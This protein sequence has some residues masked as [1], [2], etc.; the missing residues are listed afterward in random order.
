MIRIS[1]LSVSWPSYLLLLAEQINDSG[2]NGD[3]LL[4]L[5]PSWS[6]VVLPPG[7]HSKDYSVGALLLGTC[8]GHLANEPILGNLWVLDR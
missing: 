7:P 3:N 2:T 8:E 1:C 6:L 4:F 5:F